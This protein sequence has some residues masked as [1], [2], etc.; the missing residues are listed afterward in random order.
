M[1]GSGTAASGI[2]TRCGKALGGR[3][4]GGV[5]LEACDACNTLLVK[6]A[7][8]M[9]ALEALSA[10]LLESFDTDA[11]LAALPDRTGAAPCP[12]CGR[13]MEKSD[14]CG[15]KLVYFDRCNRCGLMWIGTE[16]LGAMSLMWARM[17]KRIARTRAQTAENLSGMD[18]LAQA[19]H[20]RRVVESS[21]RV[22]SL[23]R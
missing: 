6:Q 23:L 21:M 3:E 18:A 8:L 17:E 12:G 11:T 14:Y 4:V 20:V 19:A 10:P 2:C 9:P 22:V 1:S 7:A 13:A 5:G 16:E 15:A